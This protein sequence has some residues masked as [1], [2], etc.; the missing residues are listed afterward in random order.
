[1]ISRG[2]FQEPRQ[3]LTVQAMS[4]HHR[5]VQQQHRHLEPMTALQLWIGVDVEDLERRKR[6][7]AAESG[8]LCEHLVTQLTVAPM[9]DR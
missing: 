9:H 6:Q 4:A 2:A 3:L 8:E 5:A 7:R 1:M